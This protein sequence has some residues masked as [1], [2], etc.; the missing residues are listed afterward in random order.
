MFIQTLLLHTYSFP[1]KKNTMAAYEWMPHTFYLPIAEEDEGDCAAEPA[2]VEILNIE[3]LKENT[4]ILRNALMPEECQHFI[5]QAESIGRESCGYS[6]TIQKM[7]HVV[8]K[9]IPVAK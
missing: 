1:K 3:A 2:K 8:V 5:Q 9:S 6:P 4:F 7:E